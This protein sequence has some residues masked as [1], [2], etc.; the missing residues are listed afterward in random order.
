MSCLNFASSSYTST[1][2]SFLVRTEV[3][4]VHRHPL[5]FPPSALCPHLGALR[6]QPRPLLRLIISLIHHG[7]LTLT[8][9][10]VNARTEL[11]RQL[12][13]GSF[14]HHH[15]A[16]AAFNGRLKHSGSEEP[17]IGL[18]TPLGF[19]ANDVRIHSSKV[20]AAMRMQRAT[21]LGGV[22]VQTE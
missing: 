2:C 19:G 5:P 21:A 4:S 18:V 11:E 15:S 7:S 3:S 20:A 14:G 13:G 1:L 10:T 6:S 16:N 9:S 12:N 17:K 8:P 22:Q